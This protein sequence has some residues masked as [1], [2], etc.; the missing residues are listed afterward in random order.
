MNADFGLH[1][2]S[3]GLSASELLGPVHNVCPC[4]FMEES[5]VWNSVMSLIYRHFR[6]RGINKKVTDSNIFKI[7]E[8]MDIA[9]LLPLVLAVQQMF[10]RPN[11]VLPHYC[12]L[13]V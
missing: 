11:V 8:D 13:N 3:P 12:L 9:Q 1:Q 10:H 4:V 5:G 2:Q 7:E 6:E